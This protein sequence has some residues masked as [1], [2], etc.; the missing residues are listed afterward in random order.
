[1]I[2]PDQVVQILVAILTILTPIIG[3]LLRRH[4]KKIYRFLELIIKAIDQ[5]KELEDLQRHILEHIS[6]ILD[7]MKEGK[8]IPREDVEHLV[9]HVG[10]KLELAQEFYATLRELKRLITG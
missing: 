7:A 9:K 3:A 10:E 8:E 2:S 6:T 5:V 4:W 1:M